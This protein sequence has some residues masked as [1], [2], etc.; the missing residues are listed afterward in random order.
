MIE[1]NGSF[2]QNNKG[3]SL[4]ELIVAIAIGAI[5]AGSIAALIAFSI[6]MYSNE[7]VN[8]AMQYELQSSINMMID[9][10]MG[11]EVL[12]VQQDSTVNLTDTGKAYTKYALFGN[13]NAD[14]IVGGSTVKGFKGVIFV[15]SSPDSDNKFKIYMKK[16]EAQVTAPN[17]IATLASS[18]Y[19]IVS[20]ASETEAVKYLL[21]ENAT[22]FVIIP[23]PNH[24]NL[25]IDGFDPTKNTYRNPIEVKVEL[26]FEKSGW[27]SK[28][29][30]KHVDDI[31]YLRNRVQSTIY[32]DGNPFN[33]EKKEE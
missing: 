16:V 25:V 2:K 27:G 6:R 31:T 17:T 7:S 8:T 21:G 13:P 18:E 22:K 1:M 28:N 33:I 15:P 32:I 20:G 23:D 12:V 4:V 29:Y 19:G 3:L 11:A 30:S 9:E 5:V 14:I 26:Q 24:T 10:I